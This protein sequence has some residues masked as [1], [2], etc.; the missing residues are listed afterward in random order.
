M[1]KYI[2]QMIYFPYIL[3]LVFVLSH[4]KPKEINEET[5]FF[6]SFKQSKLE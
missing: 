4:A 5:S 1:W 2:A 6:S 3:S